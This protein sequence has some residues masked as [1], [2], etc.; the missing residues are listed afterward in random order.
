MVATALA[1]SAGSAPGAGFEDSFTGKA[2]GWSVAHYDFDHPA[3]ATDWRQELVGR[4]KALTLS[5]RPVGARPGRF[6]GAALRRVAP[7]GPGRY[8]AVLRAG[9]GPGVVTGFFT[10]T[11]PAYGTRHDEIDVEILGRDTRSVQI[12]VFVDGVQTAVTLPLGFDAADGFHRYEIL[13]SDR[14]V[15]WVV[16]GRWL[17]GIE[18]PPLAD[19]RLFL[20]LWAVGR[21]AEAWAGVPRPGTVTHAEVRC[22]GYAPPGRPAP[23][24]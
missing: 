2:P 15:D 5:L 20:N 11:G 12:G 23:C 10:Y 22:A 9:R 7:T 1:A 16:D 13:R 14:R 4:D 21:P 6:A 18:V 17:W 8:V 19:Q 24:P 3:F